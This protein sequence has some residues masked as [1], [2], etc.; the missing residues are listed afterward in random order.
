M[1]HM[2]A[3]IWENLV[4]RVTGPM[5]FRLVFQPCMAIFLAIRGGLKD[6]REG[7]PPYFWGLFTDPGQREAMLKDGWKAVGKV[8]IL[9][10][11]LDVVYQII[12]RRFVYP[13]EAVI[14]AVILAVLPYLLIRGPVNRLARRPRNAVKQRVAGD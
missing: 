9:A 7:K 14:V 8:F 2:L 5:N 4:A 13:G 12:E 11:V 1:E 6:A 3:R 10:I